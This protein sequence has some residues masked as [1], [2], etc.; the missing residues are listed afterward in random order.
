MRPATPR[1]LTDTEY[2]P[3]QRMFW[4]CRCGALVLKTKDGIWTPALGYPHVCAMTKEHA[5]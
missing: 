5:A 4:P 2:V 3:P 1:P